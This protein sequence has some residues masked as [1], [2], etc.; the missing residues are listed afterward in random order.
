MAL[1]IPRCLY[2]FLG[3]V[4]WIQGILVLITPLHPYGLRIQSTEGRELLT[5]SLSFLLCFGSTFDNILIIS[6]LQFKF[7]LSIYFQFLTCN[8]IYMYMSVYYHSCLVCFL[9]KTFFEI[10]FL[11]R[12]ELY[13]WKTFYNNR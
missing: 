1:L 4:V 7:T 3:E 6:L 9:V 8:R 10:M 13:A 11:A 12:F 5:P 2:G